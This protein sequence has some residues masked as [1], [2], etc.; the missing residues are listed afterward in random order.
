VPET[1]A[2]GE[3][4]KGIDGRP[5]FSRMNSAQR[6]AYDTHRLRRKYG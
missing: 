4:P 3:W 6:R 2:S 5:D 1:Q